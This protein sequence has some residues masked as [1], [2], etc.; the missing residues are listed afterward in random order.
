MDTP[1]GR[2]SKSKGKAQKA[3]VKSEESSPENPA[4]RAVPPTLPRIVIGGWGDEHE[5]F[6]DRRKP[7]AKMGWLRRRRFGSAAAKLPLWCEHGRANQDFRRKLQHSDAKWAERPLIRLRPSATFSLGRR[8]E[9]AG[10]AIARCKPWAAAK[11]PLFFPPGGLLSRLWRA[12]GAESGSSATAL[13][14]RV[15][16]SKPR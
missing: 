12:A 13:R 15:A 5:R 10:R 8:N 2:K 9:V 14:K 11:L 6:W 16:P 7:S 1:Q 3:K 4:P